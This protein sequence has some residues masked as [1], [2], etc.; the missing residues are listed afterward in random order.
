MPAPFTSLAADTAVE[1]HAAHGREVV[2]LGVEE[3]VLEQVLGRIARGR[4]ARAHHA[5][6]LDQRLHAVLGRSMRSVSR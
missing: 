2:S 1:L 6:D 5:V 3:Q 4:L